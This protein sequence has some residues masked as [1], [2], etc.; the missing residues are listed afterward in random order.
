[1]ITP[2]S[3]SALSSNNNSN[4]SNNNNVAIGYSGSG[5]GNSSSSGNSSGEEKYGKDRRIGQGSGNA[6]V[7]ENGIAKLEMG[8]LLGKDDILLL[9]GDQIEDYIYAAKTKLRLSTEQMDFLK[10]YRRLIKNKEYAQ[11]SRDKK[12]KYIFELESELNSAISSISKLQQDINDLSIKNAQLET[13][14][15][16]LHEELSLYKE[17]WGNIIH[18]NPLTSAPIPLSSSSS[19]TSPS[20]SA[21]NSPDNTSL[22]YASS[23]AAAAAAA[24]SSSSMYGSNQRSNFFIPMFA[25]CLIGLC[26]GLVMGPLAG[27]V[28]GLSGFVG[29]GAGGNSTVDFFTNTKGTGRT[30]KSEVAQSQQ[31]SFLSWIKS[32][33]Y[34]RDVDDLYQDKVV[35]DGGQYDGI[36]GGDGDGE[37]TNGGNDGGGSVIK[38]DDVDAVDDE[39]KILPYSELLIKNDLLSGKVHNGQNKDDLKEIEN[40]KDIK[41]E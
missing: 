3:T 27:V 20:D 8:E 11:Q 13:E 25:V 23:A 33:V 37:S 17:R 14:N 38:N 32:V 4:S 18:T 28:P 36:D 9:S 34:R 2:P 6:E 40:E 30:L 39:E 5:S 15:R 1:M 35:L 31:N 10:K 41:N 12:K 22:I 26:L 19:S 16:S 7:M 24:A 21:S 29:G